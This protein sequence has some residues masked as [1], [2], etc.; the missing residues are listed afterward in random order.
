MSYSFTVKA[1]TK[2]QAL[3]AAR[4]ELVKVHTAQAWHSHD[5]GRAHAAAE[6]LVSLLAEDEDDT[7]DVSISMNGSI[8]VTDAGVQQVSCNVDAQLVTR[9]A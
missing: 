9:E 2:P 1:P 4:D 8:T 7:Q 6:A 3:T 5:F